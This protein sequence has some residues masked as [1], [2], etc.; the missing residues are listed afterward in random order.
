MQKGYWV[1]QVDVQNMD[2]YQN[3][4]QANGPALAKFGARFL[5]RGGQFEVAEGRSRSR[6]V[7]VEFP[8]YEA[9]K[10]CWKSPE[11]L[12]AKTMQQSGATIDLIIIEGFDGPQP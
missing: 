5:I 10:A 3:Y 7:V 9:A 8:S 11:Y 12:A 2:G 4:L 1:A 6:H